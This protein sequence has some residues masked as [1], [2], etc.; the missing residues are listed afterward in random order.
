MSF[1]TVRF[2]DGTDAIPSTIVSGSPEITAVL[3]RASF[4]E[5][6]AKVG[7]YGG[8][9][10]DTHVPP[11]KYSFDS[12]DEAKPVTFPEEATRLDAF[13]RR[14]VGRYAIEITPPLNE[15]TKKLFEDALDH[16]SGPVYRDYRAGHIGSIEHITTAEL[17]QLV[18]EQAET[19]SRLANS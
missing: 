5:Q 12:R 2:Y 1:D 8:L 19:V 6:L 10:V 9:V 18:A 15:E 13:G 11:P 4:I 17:E 3:T 16:A 7:I 14:M